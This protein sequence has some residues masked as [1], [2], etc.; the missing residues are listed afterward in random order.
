MDGI[1]PVLEKPRLAASGAS[2]R[3]PYPTALYGD[4]AVASVVKRISH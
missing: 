2:V 3:M 1:S 4:C